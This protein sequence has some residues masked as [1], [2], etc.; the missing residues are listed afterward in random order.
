MNIDHLFNANGINLRKIKFLQ[1]QVV[2][3]TDSARCFYQQFYVVVK[4]ASSYRK[5]E[6]FSSLAIQIP[7][8]LGDNNIIQIGLNNLST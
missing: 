1:Q 3:Y 2:T 8:E 5:N 6:I 7:T 4:L